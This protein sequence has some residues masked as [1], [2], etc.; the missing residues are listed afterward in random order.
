[1]IPR[2]QG[3]GA[4]VESGLDPDNEACF[5]LMSRDGGRHCRKAVNHWLR[6]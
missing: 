2:D 6:T 4:L 1:L 5:V 3:H